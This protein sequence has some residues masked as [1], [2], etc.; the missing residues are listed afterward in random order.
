MEVL[1]MEITVQQGSI[2]DI[3]CD[4]AVVNLFR[5]VKSPFYPKKLKV[6]S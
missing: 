5:G 2:T 6:F 4:V 1:Q 3:E